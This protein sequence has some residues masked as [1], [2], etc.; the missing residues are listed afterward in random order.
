MTCVVNNAI[1]SPHSLVRLLVRSVHILMYVCTVC[2]AQGDDSNFAI[3]HTA[4]AL[5]NRL[6]VEAAEG[7]RSQ[8]CVRF[9]CSLR[10]Y[11]R[12]VMQYRGDCMSDAFARVILAILDTHIAKIRPAWYFR[13]PSRHITPARR[14]QA[15]YKVTRK[16][17][18]TFASI[19]LAIASQPQ[20]FFIVRACS[21]FT[22]SELDYANSSELM[23]STISA[24]FSRLRKI[25][26]LPSSG[27]THGWQ[28]K[29]Q[30][31]AS[32]R[33]SYL[34]Q[35]LPVHRSLSDS[36]RLHLNGALPSCLAIRARTC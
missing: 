11:I 13:H 7:A 33:C 35:R 24:A 8:C 9:I 14:D 20:A 3:Q 30:V 28:I 10:Q 2:M 6:I 22:E 19:L 12:D 21:Q 4:R 32:I 27:T 17:L 15:R 31:K 29:P 18:C 1:K 36:I 16:T 5:I 34:H 23:P 25:I 26:P